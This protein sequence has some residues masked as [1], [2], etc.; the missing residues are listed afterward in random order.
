MSYLSKL[1]NWYSNNY[2][3][4]YSKYYEGDYSYDLDKFIKNDYQTKTKLKITEAM[5]DNYLKKRAEEKARFEPITKVRTNWD[6]VGDALSIGI[7]PFANALHTVYENK[8]TIVGTGGPLKTP[9]E[10]FKEGIRAANPL[11]EGYEAGEHDYIELLNEITHPDTVVGKVLAGGVGFLADIFLDPTNLLGVGIIGGLVKGTGK[12]AHAI[13][14]ADDIKTIFTKYGEDVSNGMSIDSA[15]RIIIKDSQAAGRGLSIDSVNAAANKMATW[16][17]KQVGIRDYSKESLNI[18]LGNMLGGEWLFGKQLASKKVVLF[19]GDLA[20]KIGDKTLSRPY[21]KLRNAI[22]GT[23]LMRKFSNNPLFYD[24]AKKDPGEIFNFFRF[25]EDTRGLNI[26]K[27]QKE[28]RIREYAAKNLQN[29]TPADHKKLIEL[30]EDPTQWRFVTE[31]FN[32]INTERGLK[33]HEN[34]RQNYILQRREVQSIL[35]KQSTIKQAIKEKKD[36]VDAGKAAIERLTKEYSDTLEKIDLRTIHDLETLDD[37]VKALINHQDILRQQLRDAQDLRAAKEIEYI[38]EIDRVKMER[39]DEIQRQMDEVDEKAEEVQKRIDKIN[40]EIGKIKSESRS[41]VE[42][43]VLMKDKES[44]EAHVLRSKIAEYQQQI[45][46]LQ[47]GYTEQYENFSKTWNEVLKGIK[48]GK[49]VR[50]NISELR[51]RLFNDFDSLF[52]KGD[53]AKATAGSVADLKKMKLKLKDRAA[54]DLMDRTKVTAKDMRKVVDGFKSITKKE[55]K[56]YHDLIDQLE[57][58]EDVTDV[59]ALKNKLIMEIG[60]FLVGD[61]RFISDLTTIDNVANLMRRMKQGNTPEEILEFIAAN[62]IYYNGRSTEIFKFIG[63]I[64][65]YGYGKSARTWNDYYNKPMKKVINKIMKDKSL[66]IKSKDEIKRL[67]TSD[68]DTRESID[69]IFKVIEKTEALTYQEK[70]DVARVIQAHILRKRLLNECFSLPKDNWEEAFGKLKTR[71]YDEHVLSKTLNKNVDEIDATRQQILKDLEKD[72]RRVDNFP[73][74]RIVF[75]EREKEI[76]RDR[77]RERLIERGVTKFGPKQ[78]EFIERVIDSAE[79]ILKREWKVTYG[80]LEDSEENWLIYLAWKDANVKSGA[81]EARSKMVEL[82][83]EEIKRR[84]I[85]SKRESIMRDARPG[86][87]IYCDGNKV[88]T[89]EEVVLKDDGIPVFKGKDADD[90]LSYAIKLEDIISVMKKSEVDG[91]EEMAIKS[92]VVSARMRKLEELQPEMEKAQKEL[93]LLEAVKDAELRATD[94]ELDKAIKQMEDLNKQIDVLEVEKKKILDSKNDIGKAKPVEKVMREHEVDYDELIREYQESSA[95]YVTDRDVYL[96]EGEYMYHGVGINDTWFKETFIDEQ[97]NLVMRGSKNFDDKQNGISFTPSPERA[98]DYARRIKGA[99]REVVNNDNISKIIRIKK[100]ALEKYKTG[101]ENQ[102]EFFAWEDR[103][104]IPKGE[105]DYADLGHKLQAEE[106]AKAQKM[107]NDDV[108]EAYAKEAEANFVYEVNS[109]RFKNKDYKNKD[110]IREELNRRV[111]TGKINKEEYV[112]GML[113]I[114]KDNNFHGAEDIISQSRLTKIKSSKTGEPLYTYKISDEVF[115]DIDV[116]RKLIEDYYDELKQKPLIEYE[117]ISNLEAQLKELDEKNALNP[118]LE[119]DAKYGWKVKDDYGYD[120]PEGRRAEAELSKYDDVLDRYNYVADRN[121][122]KKKL[123]E[124]KPSVAKTDADEVI[125]RKEVDELDKK[126]K[127]MMKKN[128]ELKQQINNRAYKEA[129]IRRRNDKSKFAAKAWYINH[130]NKWQ[131]QMLEHEKA[132]R[133]LQD[134]INMNIDFITIDDKI[135]NMQEMGRILNN[136]DA[137][138]T[139]MRARLGSDVVD[140]IITK[141]KFD[142]IEVVLKDDVDADR[143]IRDIANHLRKDFIDIAKEEISIGKLRPEQL[144]SMIMRYLPHVATDAGQKYFSGEQIEKSIQG[145]GD[146]LGFGRVWNP[147]GISRSVKMIKNANGDWVKEFN[148]MEENE[149]FKQF[150]KG[151]NAFSENIYDIYLARMTKHTELMYDNQLMED[152]LNLFGKDIDGDVERNYQAVMNCGMLKN[153]V[154]SMTKMLIKLDTEDAIDNHFRVG[155]IKNPY[156]DPE[157]AVKYGDDVEEYDLPFVAQEK[158]DVMKVIGA[159]VDDMVQKLKDDMFTSGHINFSDIEKYRSKFYSQLIRKETKRFYREELHPEAFANAQKSAKMIA[160]SKL[161]WM[162]KKE[163]R[164]GQDKAAKRQE[165][166]DREYKKALNYELTKQL[167]I[168]NIDWHNDTMRGVMER[169]GTTR[170]LGDLLM[171]MINVDKNKDAFLKGEHAGLLKRHDKNTKRSFE[172]IFKQWQFESRGGPMEMNA[173]ELRD[174]RKMFNNL[175]H[176]QLMKF[177]AEE[178]NEEKYGEILAKRIDELYKKRSSEWDEFNAKK[179]VVKQVHDAMVNKLN[180]ARKIQ[181]EKDHDALLQFVDKFT[182]WV[183]LMQTTVLPGWHFSNKKSNIFNNWLA[184]GNDALNPHY[185]LAAYKAMRGKGEFEEAF[186]IIDE[187]GFVIG[188]GNWKDLYRKAEEYGVIDKNFVAADLGVGQNSR[189]LLSKLNVTGALDPTDT[190]NFFAFKYGA[191]AGNVIEGTDRLIHFMSMVRHGKTYEEAAESVNHFLFDYSDVTAFEASVMKRIIP[192]YTWMRKNVPLQ[193]EQLI[194][195]PKKYQLVTKTQYAIESYTPEE[196]R[197]DERYV[198]DFA[199]DWIQTPFRIKNKQGKEEH[200]LYNSKL[201]YMDISRLGNG[202]L[203]DLKTLFTQSNLLIKVPLE[204]MNNY[205]TFYEAPIMK[206]VI[207]DVTTDKGF[208]KAKPYLGNAWDATKYMLNQLTPFS[209]AQKFGEKK[210]VDLGL[211]AVST[212]TGEKILSYDYETYKYLKIQQLKYGSEGPIITKVFKRH[213]PEMVEGYNSVSSATSK[214]GREQFYRD[215]KN[216]LAKRLVKGA[217][218]NAEE[219][220]GALRPISQSRYEKL[221]PEEKLMYTPPDVKTSVALNKEAVRLA[222]L[223]KAERLSEVGRNWGA[224]GTGATKL[225]WSFLE[226]TDLGNINEQYKYGEVTRIIDGDTF[227]VNLGDGVKKQVRMLLIDTPESVK[228]DV[229]EQPGS[230]AASEYTKKS[231]IGKDVKIIFDTEYDEDDYGRML[232]YVEYDDGKDIGL[233]LVQQGLAKTQYIIQPPYDR[234]NLYKKEQ[235]I[236]AENDEG[237]WNIPFYATNDDKTPFKRQYDEAIV[238]RLNKLLN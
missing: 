84:H 218:L 159:Q 141:E 85:T 166:Y 209:I 94:E 27:V 37:T 192:F 65:G 140:K 9:W 237:V 142:L 91:I 144:E 70:L 22:Y 184:I 154:K 150:L 49:E 145:M 97:G 188:Q 35:K 130:R 162:L 80:S 182:H 191:K 105:W 13:Q 104:T 111:K 23:Q 135:K 230:K 50:E 57:K 32:F 161:E 44:V 128:E 213:F 146:N 7:Y 96:P 133:E 179:P 195:Q 208:D 122:N 93:D 117:D 203:D 167:K 112:Q 236:A 187:N 214:E 48:G 229:I 160:D 176:E 170:D 83:G 103:I 108:F 40:M 19:K 132:Y 107:S 155:K 110:V 33:E 134:S 158:A 123:Y 216:A 151:K 12:A 174:F 129:D 115:N 101:Y 81:K 152:M 219:Y 238:R 58:I 26:S 20:Q 193:L 72:E 24:M 53:E 119:R 137:F 204:L 138:D 45:D 207:P 125:S 54:V 71:V 63:D 143:Q 156:Y 136:H 189:G 16:Y 222:E 233:E 99:P 148:V 183:K 66:D 15:R 215:A 226:R 197:M 36:N 157:V 139:F 59:Y 224:L 10:A 38:K 11:G 87:K 217:P 232:A 200:I 194:E 131:N 186:D 61:A 202:P 168:A 62:E 231:L 86:A 173:D 114:M 185:Q 201:P 109:T 92:P 76:T 43:L 77:I 113:K 172:K 75:T 51:S 116:Q 165:I 31:K 223:A 199:L 206:N 227:E 17:N 42:K 210:G 39:A 5:V 234:L 56:K 1:T 4:N 79:K 29:L 221:S 178:V 46:N 177:L 121:A 88:Y 153:N 47:N 82:I 28:E 228:R 149:Y 89:I 78:E 34:L 73:E 180:Q 190:K 74:E 106:F 127:E 25:M 100:N 64:I 205:N 164:L 225:M 196:D 18:S 235:N 220:V 147:F 14:H 3:N 169:T 8:N 52:T 6:R 69:Q 98:E 60:E 90:G 95:K 120:S 30:M 67:I 124:E 181:I 102:E 175:N 41:Y 126:I 55:K 163:Y 171:P 2:E 21:H 68:A 198:N 211:H 118:L 212:L